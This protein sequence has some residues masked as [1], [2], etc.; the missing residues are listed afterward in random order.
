[1]ITHH[2][3]SADSSDFSD[4]L[5]PPVSL[6]L[7]LSIYLSP[8][9]PIIHRFPA[10]LPN[11]SLCPHRSNIGKFLLVGQHWRFHVWW[12][13][14]KRQLWIRPCLSS[15]VL[16][17]LVRLT[18]MLLK[19]G[20]GTAA[21]LWGVAARIC[22]KSHVAF[23]CSSHLAFSRCVLLTSIY[24]VVLTHP[25]HEKNVLFVFRK[26]QMPPA[27]CSCL[28]SRDSAWAGVFAR[29]ARSSA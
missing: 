6:S 23:L 26:R 2:H 7:Y 22:S 19:I 20:D 13:I 21:V 4:F 15:S 29:S 10:G 8:S 11:Y 5:P 24:T 27:V 1:M 16:A 17:C 12:S 18:K 9:F 25:Q 28:C 3:Q 14:E